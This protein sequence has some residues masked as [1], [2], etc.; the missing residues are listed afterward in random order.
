MGET[1]RFTCILGDIYYFIGTVW[2]DKRCPVCFVHLLMTFPGKYIEG[3]V[4]S[5]IFHLSITF[6]L[7]W[8]ACP[9]LLCAPDPIEFNFDHLTISEG[10]SQ[11]SIYCIIEDHEG[12][13]WFGSG[14][15]LNKYDGYS[16]THYRLDPYN[17]TSISD[18]S[19]RALHVDKKGRLWIGTHNGG[20]NLF[21]KYTEK[22]IAYRHDP[23][24]EVGLSSNRVREIDE[25]S[26]GNLWIATN[27]GVSIFDCQEDRFVSYDF[28]HQGEKGKNLNSL[29]IDSLGVVW[30]GGGKGKIYRR[31]LIRGSFESYT[32]SPSVRSGTPTP[33][34]ITAIHM[35]QDNTLW[36]GTDSGLYRARHTD[37]LTFEPY[38]P[39][40]DNSCSLGSSHISIVAGDRSGRLWV[41][42]HR[43]GLHLYD[44]ENDRFIVFRHDAKKLYSLGDNS[45]QSIYESSSGILW[46]GTKGEGVSRHDP[47]KVHFKTFRNNSYEENSVTSGS[48]WTFCEDQEGAIWVGT[49]YGLNRFDRKTESFTRFTHDPEDL[50]SL[51]DNSVRAIQ[52]DRLGVLWIGTD[53]GL[54]C[55]DPSSGN[56]ASYQHGS[57]DSTKLSNNR[58]R[59][60][61]IDRAGI[62][63]I[64]TYHGLNLFDPESRKC[65]KCYFHDP[66]DSTTISSDRIWALCQDSKNR[67]WVGTANG[68]NRFDPETETFQRYQY[69]P[70]N[71]SSIRSNSVYSIYD[72]MTGMLWVGT[73]SGGLN[74]FDPMTGDFSSFDERDGMPNPTVYGILED[75]DAYL[76]LSSNH[77][78]SKFDPTSEIFTNF[79]VSD[80][81]QSN[82]FNFGAYYKCRD[83]KMLFGGVDGFNMFHPDE[84]QWKKQGASILLTKF[85]YPG[86]TLY[87]PAITN[88]H[89][90]LSHQENFFSFEFT[91]LDCSTSK[92]NRYAYFL[93]NFDKEW[94]HCSYRNYGN[95]TNLSGGEY[96]LK[97]KIANISDFSASNET[98]IKVIV[99]PAPWNT[100]T[101]YIF[102]LITLTALVSGFIRFR[103]REYDRRMTRKKK[104]EE[105]ARAKS[106]QQA[107]L[108]KKIPQVSELDMAGYMKTAKEIGGDYY[109]IILSPD[110]RKLYLAV[111]DVSGKGTPASLVMVAV[112]TILRSLTSQALSPRDILIRAN[113]LLYQD[114][115]DAK[116]PGMVTMMLMCWDLQKKKMVYTGAG[117]EYILVYRGEQDGQKI[118]EAI[119][120]GGMWLGIDDNIDELMTEKQLLFEPNDTILLY[121]DGITES[122]NQNMEMYG[123]ERLKNFLKRHGHLSAKKIV[124]RLLQ[125]VEEFSRQALQHDDMT[126]VVIKRKGE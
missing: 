3:D 93:E 1:R 61:M 29:F 99:K 72:D 78:I 90:V 58:I 39:G 70:H 20:L 119:P 33:H 42:T 36:V 112:R 32:I 45:I 108:P 43:N 103:T 22:F 73:N 97:I 87:L 46:V 76:W 24:E 102:Y 62:I 67:I 64:G 30:T 80:G 116:H 60:L 14:D 92:R 25:D 85:S 47:N 2:L 10:L 113:Q 63:W 31:D 8:T 117:H 104:A 59:S 12:F 111:A 6:I 71:P 84:I 34:L 56:F 52:T 13:L 88:N 98:Q 9:P 83:G 48:I 66:Q 11:N 68:L 15:G 123:V 16:F 57:S 37:S 55:Y 125:N 120:S 26:A 106:I 101:A 44:K 7:W 100:L 114:H 105:M 40:S 89:I 95:Y 126:V 115:S 49:E 75:N 96:I 81:L 107:M 91:S 18:N 17:S 54:S 94:I 110:E 35:D 109:D 4:V 122:H 77:G 27:N 121:T 53:H 38:D 65:V 86:G 79:D 21:D 5:K 74:Y 41:G 51:C 118:C 124:D 28:G 82:E 19:I 23:Y 69:D 50:R